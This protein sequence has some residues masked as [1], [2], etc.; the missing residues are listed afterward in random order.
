MKHERVLA[1]WGKEKVVLRW[2]DDDPCSWMVKRFRK[3]VF[4]NK[5]IYSAWF[6]L[7]EQAELYAENLKRSAGL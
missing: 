2:Y 3:G 4:G 7:E 6:S 1:E 5:C